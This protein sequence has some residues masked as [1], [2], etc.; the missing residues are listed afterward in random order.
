M[1]L[2]FHEAELMSSR[3]SDIMDGEQTQEEINRMQQIEAD[4]K[5]HEKEKI[6]LDSETKKIQDELFTRAV[7][8]AE[9]IEKEKPNWLKNKN[10]AN[11][12]SYNKAK[13]RKLLYYE[14]SYADVERNGVI[15]RTIP[16]VWQTDIESNQSWAF[17][18]ADQ[19]YGT[20]R[21]QPLWPWRRV[22]RATVIL[23]F[24]KGGEWTDPLLGGGFKAK[25]DENA[26]TQV[27]VRANYTKEQLDAFIEEG[28]HVSQNLLLYRQL[29]QYLKPK[30]NWNFI[31]II[32]VLILVVVGIWFFATHQQILSQIGGSLGLK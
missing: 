32:V 6:T 13:P 20:L 25:F 19:F 5:T 31:V 8:M 22:K 9:Y 2:T 14:G 11:I 3:Q 10:A 4:R 1:A 12:I 28:H 23:P 15:L 21:K 16:F 7:K 26:Q 29:Q 18:W 24:N 30:A 27:P 17:C